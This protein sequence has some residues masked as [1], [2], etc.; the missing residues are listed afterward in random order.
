MSEIPVKPLPRYAWVV[1]CSCFVLGIYLTRKE[2]EAKQRAHTRNNN[3]K[4]TVTRI[5][6][7]TP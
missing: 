2:A 4:P 5:P 1:C 7:R 3:A 6:V